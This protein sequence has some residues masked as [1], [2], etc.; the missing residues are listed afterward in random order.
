MKKLG[1]LVI[2]FCLLALLPGTGFSQNTEKPAIYDPEADI[3]ACIEAALS[4]AG[5]ENRHI[6]LMFGANWCPW[7]HKL[8]RLFQ[9]DKAI[10]ETLSNGYIVILVDIGETKDKPLNRDLEEKYRVKGFGYPCL[11]VLDTKGKLLAAQSTG[12]L[13]DAKLKAHAPERVLAFL[14]A[15]LPAPK[16]E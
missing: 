11:A 1:I 7:C 3:P 14:K 10:S 15:E 5:L 16:A 2:L 9:E 13:E 4:R 12:V 8:H 6:L